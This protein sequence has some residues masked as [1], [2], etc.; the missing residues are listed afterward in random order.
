MTEDDLT[1]ALKRA[2]Y[3]HAIALIEILERRRR[4]DRIAFVAFV[5]APLIAAGLFLALVVAVAVV[6]LT[7]Q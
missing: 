1:R 5:L 4:H 7:G 3:L 2:D 6:H